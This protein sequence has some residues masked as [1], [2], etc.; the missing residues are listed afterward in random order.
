M[1]SRLNLQ[2]ISAVIRDLRFNTFHTCLSAHLERHGTKF[3]YP[4]GHF[5][6]RGRVIE[7]S[8]RIGLL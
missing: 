3:I 6:S 7:P 4:E 1:Y 2:F 5:Y 8:K